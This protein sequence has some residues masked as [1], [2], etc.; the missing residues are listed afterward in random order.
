MTLLEFVD[1]YIDGKKLSPRYCAELHWTVGALDRWHGRHVLLTELSEGLFDRWLRALRQDP[2]RPRSKATTAWHRNALLMLWRASYATGLTPIV[3]PLVKRPMPP[4]STEFSR[5]PACQPELSIT[6]YV[7]HYQLKTGCN[8]NSAEQYRIAGQCLERF[9]KRRVKLAELDHTMLNE[10]LAHI[11]R[12]LKP[13]SVRSRRNHLT[14]LWRSAHADGLCPTTYMPERARKVRLPY[15]ANKAWTIDQV[16][17][18]VAVTQ[19][20]D[21]HLPNDGVSVRFFWEFALRAEWDSALR[22]GDLFT[23]KVGDFNNDGEA[24]ITQR[25]T[26]RPTFVRLNPKTVAMCEES[27][28]RDRDRLLPWPHTYEHF[29]K[30]FAKLVARAGLEGTFRKL[31]RSSA[32]HCEIKHPGTGAVH[33]GHLTGFK[34]ADTHYFDFG[35]IAQHKPQVEEL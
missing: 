34:T 21:G 17:Q 32:T 27:H 15:R 19:Q 24:V 9:C 35:M 20:L 31:R 7:K 13:D 33:L 4:G 10:W 12:H 1:V 8:D 28:W 23:A 11:E 6:Q 26:G 25:K 5:Q 16:R 29:R 30:E 2:E 3:P 18:M 14:A 22:L